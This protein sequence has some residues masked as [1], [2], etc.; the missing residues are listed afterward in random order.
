MTDSGFSPPSSPFRQLLGIEIEES[1]D[2]RT[3]ASLR[4]EPHHTNAFGQ[5]HGGAI[6]SLADCAFGVA[7]NRRPEP[8]VAM[9]MHTR[10]LR[11]ADV[12]Q[13]LRAIVTPVHSGRLT[14]FFRIEVVDENN[15]AIA[16]LTATGH[17]RGERRSPKP[18]TGSPG[19]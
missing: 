7:N 17:L 3:V 19:S 8:F 4:L 10:F 16:S 6:F 5:A 13:T 2:A 1:T 18:P 12:G 9:E 11:P 14:S 15:R